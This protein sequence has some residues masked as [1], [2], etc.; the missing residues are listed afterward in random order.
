M[1]GVANPER[2]AQTGDAFDT[3]FTGGG[4]A[5]PVDHRPIDTS[6]AG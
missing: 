3:K 5:V 2:S 6:A 1:T 4:I